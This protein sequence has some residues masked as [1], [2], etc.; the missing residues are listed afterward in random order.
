MTSMIPY[1]AGE[2]EPFTPASL[3]GLD[4]P[5]VLYLRWGTPREKQRMRRR[6]AE[7]Q[8]RRHSTEEVREELLKGLRD[9][10]SQNAAAEW[11]PRIRAWWEAQDAYAEEWKDVPLTERPAFEFDGEAAIE[12]TLRQIGRDWEPYAAM[13]GDNAEIEPLMMD[14]IVSLIVER[15]EGI[16]PPVWRDGR[17]F[18]TDSATNIGEALD[19][20]AL[21]IQ[22][23][24]DFMPSQELRAECVRR[25]Y[26]DRDSVKGSGSPPPSSPSPHDS[27]DGKA[28]T[29]GKSAKTPTKKTRAR[30][31]TTATST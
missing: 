13:M 16:T 31:S 24:D 8:L 12:L 18:T 29:A 22:V 21:D 9:I 11:E 17:H 27:N 10:L 2:A 4:N 3:A 15:F 1:E 5:P 20:L 26:L 6:M 23:D 7:K 28:S 14:I 25:L 30:S 19:R